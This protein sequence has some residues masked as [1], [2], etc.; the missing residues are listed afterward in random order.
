MDR[1]GGMFCCLGGLMGPPGVKSVDMGSLV[2]DGHGVGEWGVSKI[3]EFHQLNW[4]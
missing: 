2:R 1:F 4:L 3:H